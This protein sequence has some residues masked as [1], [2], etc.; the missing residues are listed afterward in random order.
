MESDV[1]SQDDNVQNPLQEFLL[2]NQNVKFI[3]CIW[4]DYFGITRVRKFTLARAAELSNTRGYITLNPSSMACHLDGA[5][6]QEISSP[7]ADRMRPDWTS[8]RVIGNDPTR[9]AVMCW[10][11]GK[12]IVSRNALPA[13]LLQPQAPYEDEGAPA[14]CPR[15][16]LRRILRLS[17]Q[18][19]GAHFQVGF[20]LEFYLLDEPYDPVKHNPD[21]DDIEPPAAAAASDAVVPTTNNDNKP[22]PPPPPPP[23]TQPQRDRKTYWATASS[24]RGK[25]GDVV[26]ACVDALE[27]CGIP[28]DHFQAQK[29]TQ[30]FKISLGPQEAMRAADSV[31]LATEIIKRVALKHG[32]YATFF[33]T[34]F[35]NKPSSGLH[36]HISIH[37]VSSSACSAYLAGTL[38]RLP[39]LAVFGMPNEVSF[40]RLGGAPDVSEWVSW[41]TENRNAAIRQIRPNHWELRIVDATANIYLVLATCIGA[42]LLGIKDKTPLLWEDCKGNPSTMDAF[43]RIESGINTLLP[44]GLGVSLKILNSG[45]MGLD[46]VLGEGILGFYRLL[47]KADKHRQDQMGGREVEVFLAKE[48]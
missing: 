24:L 40:T 45:F 43:Q 9:A 37:G 5:P 14:R 28:V 29:C 11:I 13:G 46:K 19:H 4:V 1:A 7:G 38:F 44:D 26:E 8:L 36:T 16:A 25:H 31:I 39:L 27:E 47:R 42:G 15:T 3:E 48:F 30:Q 22:L 41:G 23:S 21:P 18:A 6:I 17:H 12:E 35:S 33:P 34:P 2:Y 10:Y 32:L 20:E